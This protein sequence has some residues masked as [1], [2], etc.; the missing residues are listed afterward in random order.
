MILKNISVKTGSWTDK[1]GKERGRYVTIGHIHEGEHGHYITLE[2]QY[3][4][5]AFPRKDGDM[6]V[7]ANL[8]DPKPKE[9]RQE[10]PKQPPKSPAD[11][12]FDSDI[13]F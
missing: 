6:R 8:Y 11:D 4:L 3:N 2:S 1:E 12:D 13:P 9:E 5:A 10:A 7:I